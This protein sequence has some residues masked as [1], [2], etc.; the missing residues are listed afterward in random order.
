M[1]F[2]AIIAG[3]G[4]IGSDLIGAS[5]AG[6]AA[7]TQANAANQAAGLQSQ[8]LQQI[9]GNAQP[10]QAAGTNA[11]TSILSGLGLQQGGNGTGAL[12]RQFTAADYQQS[13]GYQFQMSQ[14]LDAINNSA[15]ARG[16]SGNTLKAL[17]GYGQGL[18]NQDYQQAY[19][20]FVNSQK[21]SYGMLEGLVGGGQQANQQVAGAGTQL[22]GQ[23]AN[24]LTQGANATAAGQIAQGN[25]FG[26]IF[27]TLF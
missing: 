21:Q 5:A 27:S 12:N 6:D 7:S 23:Q 13:P 17:E 22:V 26:D 10:Y 2:F 19:T 3:A 25:A 8:F 24:Y 4:A 15:S 20:N 9:Q 14:G 1:P 16:I 18:A 11:L